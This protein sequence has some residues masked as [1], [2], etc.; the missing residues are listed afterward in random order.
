MHQE[1]EP[2]NTIATNRTIGAITLGPQYNLQ[3][4][5]C[6][7]I[8]LT[9]KRLQRSHFTPV[10]MTEDVIER[11]NTFNTKSCPVDLIFGDFNYQPIP[12][13]YYNTTNDYDYDSTQ[14]DSDLTNNEG[15]EYAVVKNDENN[16][17]SI[18]ASEIDPP[19][20]NL[21]EIEGVGRMGNETEERK[22]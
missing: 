14:I 7:E 3:G 11:Y 9:G 4:G 22:I 19:Q 17:D 13:T 10:N 16:D 15:V 6:V 18:L 1:D 12:S 8:L 2:Q 21:L 5:Y 20:T